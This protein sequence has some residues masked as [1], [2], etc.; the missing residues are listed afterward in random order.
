MNADKTEGEDM[1]DVI[2]FTSYN[3]QGLTFRGHDES[4]NSSNQG[5]FLELL[6]FLAKHNEEIDKVVLENALENHQ[7]T[8]SDIQKE[9]A[10]AAANE[11]LDVI[12]KDLGDSS[13]AILVDEARDLSVKEQLAIVLRYVDKK[14]H[15][16]KR[17]LGITHV[18]NTTTAV[19]KMAIESSPDDLFAAFNKDNML[20]LAQFYPNDFS[21]IQL[22]TLDNQLETYII[23]MRSSEEFATLKGI[24]QLAEKMVEMKK[25][26]TYPLVYSLV[27][28]SLILPVATGT[29]ERAFSSMNIVKNRLR[30]RM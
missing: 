17:L 27:T 21:A 12:L 1:G 2:G 23:D 26:I 14:G 18:S 9:I 19:L 30:N 4:K 20:R 3:Q 16:I 5:N 11:T 28:L 7:M 15:V 13:F 10:N 24:R 29:V 8:A 25:D 6:Q 22:M